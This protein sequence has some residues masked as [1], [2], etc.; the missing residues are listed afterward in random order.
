[1]TV[2]DHTPP[3]LASIAA[4]ADA[5][6]VGEW[7]D[8]DTGRWSRPFTGTRHR[9]GVKVGGVQHDDGTVGRPRST[10]MTRS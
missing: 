2:A 5:T 8:Y 1:M 4:P 6:H 7:D 3:H 10:V 9:R